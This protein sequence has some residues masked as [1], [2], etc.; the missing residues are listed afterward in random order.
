MFFSPRYIKEAKHLL[1]GARKVLRYRK[2]ILTAQESGRL[3]DCIRNLRDA[4]SQRNRD[5]VAHATQAL[6]ACA[7]QVVPQR[8]HPVWRENVE[9]LLVAIILAAGIRAYFLQPFKIPSGSMQPT[10]FG[11]VGQPS[12]APAPNPIRRVFDFVA[13]GRSYLNVV[14][15]S[16]ETVLHMEERPYLNFFTF[17]RITCTQNT[18]W[19]FA[20]IA[21]VYSYFGV[22]EGRSYSAGEPIVQGS[23]TSG[24]QLFVDKFSYNFIFPKRDQVFVFKTINIPKIQANL[25]EGVESEHYI[26]RLSGVSGDKLRI[27]SPLLFINGQVATEPG[28]LRVMSCKNG[29]RG[30]SNMALFSYLSAP[31]DSFT[32]PSETYFALG[33]NSYNSSDSRD[34]GIVPQENV[35]GRASFVLWPFSSRWGWIR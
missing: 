27:D 3:E 24:D 17:T 14:A 9:V 25:P 12:S 6:E 26:K 18:Y 8:S 11:I 7:I 19:V 1:H 20:P 21:T 28:F 5:Q 33:D 22:R 13:L 35:V 23:V 15:K 29:Y 4:I 34:W 10:L 2:D 16:D 32:V 31:E 30:Y